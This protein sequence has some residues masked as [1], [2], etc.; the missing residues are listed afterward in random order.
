[1]IIVTNTLI[2]LF[3]V[4]NKMDIKMACM[5]QL[6]ENYSAIFDDQN[7]NST[8]YCL[9]YIHFSPFL[10]QKSINRKITSNV[11]LKINITTSTISNKCED[12][13]PT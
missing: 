7:R 13:L 8:N 1:M 4:S 5:S 11:Y 6:K 12:E 3:K 9:D 2:T 10:G